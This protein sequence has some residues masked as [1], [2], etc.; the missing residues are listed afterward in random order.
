MNRYMCTHHIPPGSVTPDQ[1][2]EMATELQ[3]DE[4]VKGYR[5]FMNLSEGKAVCIIEAKDA[6]AVADWFKKM[7]MPYDEITQVELEGERGTMCEVS[8]E[9]VCSGTCH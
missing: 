7:D 5:S 3:Q 4:Q 1:A 8:Q 2:R 6:R 9:C